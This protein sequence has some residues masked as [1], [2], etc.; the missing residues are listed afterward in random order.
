LAGNFVVGDPAATGLISAAFSDSFGLLK[1]GSAILLTD[2]RGHVISTA[3]APD[4]PALFAFSGDGQA[5]LAY[6]LNSKVLL[7]WDGNTFAPVLLNGQGLRANAI[8]SVAAPDQDHAAFIVER[9]GGLWDVRVRLATG[10]VDAQSALSGVNAPAFMFANGEVVS[11]DAG[12]LVLRKADGSQ[13]HIAAELPDNYAFRQMGN[14]WLS[15]REA[16]GSRQ[17]AV[18][19]I[20]NRE[21]VYALPEASQ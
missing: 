8:W 10:E 9:K 19:F 17:F 16:A 11:R 20:R 12:G 14:G 1:T 15:L 2:A 21:G 13:I 5:A 3:N 6:I 4:G 7:H 18:R